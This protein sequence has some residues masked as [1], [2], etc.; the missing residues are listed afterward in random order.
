M[1]IVIVVLA[2]GVLALAALAGNGRFGEMPDP[3]VDDFVPEPPAGSLSPQAL[4]DAT[5]GTT[6]YGYSP[7]QVRRFVRAAARQW[8]DER[9]ATQP[10][11]E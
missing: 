5:F 11:P 4:A 2:L 7:E 10:R 1:E 8:Q 3:V 9:D 6:R